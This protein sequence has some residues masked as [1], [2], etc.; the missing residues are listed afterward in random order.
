MDVTSSAD[1]VSGLIIRCLLAREAC[2]S[3]G[4]SFRAF[5]S[6]NEVVFLKIARHWRLVSNSVCGSHLVLSGAQ[7]SLGHVHGHPYSGK[8]QSSA[9]AAYS[10][11]QAA[12]VNS[13]SPSTCAPTWRLSLQEEERER[14]MDFVPEESAVNTDL[15]EV[16]TCLRA[17]PDNTKTVACQRKICRVGFFGFVK[18]PAVTCN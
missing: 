3:P 9:L 4:S 6:I 18:S 13:L 16:H 5:M 8:M 14:R 1:L 12:H 15:I 11:W 17:L 7:P 2:D 10:F